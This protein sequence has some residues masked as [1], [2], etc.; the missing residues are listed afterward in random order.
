MIQHHYRLRLLAR[1]EHE[2]AVTRLTTM[3]RIRKTWLT[4]E[5]PVRRRAQVFSNTPRR[6]F[7]G[8]AT[9]AV[10]ASVV[11]VTRLIRQEREYQ[12]IFCSKRKFDP[13]LKESDD[14]E[15]ALKE[16]SAEREAEEARASHHSAWP[17]PN[18]SWCLDCK[19]ARV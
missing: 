16:A 2:E 9:Q 3:E 18:D 4:Q 12:R 8:K 17:P 7:E 1:I 11:Q 15:L 19:W 6:L 5:E 14:P 10:R 13:F